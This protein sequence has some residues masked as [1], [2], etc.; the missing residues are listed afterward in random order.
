M[1]PSFTLKLYAFLCLALSISTTSFSQTC[2]G[3]NG[4]NC[5]AATDQ[6][7]TA[8]FGNTSGNFTY[9]PGAPTGGYTTTNGNVNGFINIFSYTLSVQSSNFLVGGQITNGLNRIVSGANAATIQIYLAGTNTIL[10]QTPVT[11]QANG[12]VSASFSGLAGTNVRVNFIFN[13]TTNGGVTFDNFGTDPAQVVLPVRFIGFEGKKTNTGLQLT[14]KVAGE[15]NVNRYE[16]ERNNGA[17]FSKIGTVPATGNSSYTFTDAA[18]HGGA[19]VYRIKNVDNDGQI[20][21]STLLSFRN[22]VGSAVFRAVPT[23]AHSRT[24]VQHAAATGVETLTLSTAD[25]R[26]VRTVRP[27]A[28]SLK[29]NVDLS[30]LQSGLYLLK[31]SN[32]KGSVETAKL[33]KQ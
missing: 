29:T 19:V 33:V 9:N 16:V 7:A 12:C 30:S 14:W 25:G 15:I 1:K 24:E 11:V 21:Y 23:V 5:V 26:V 27:A 13:K 2:T 28:G 8:S 31:W 18:S 4:T 10:C 22:G 32:G 3:T 6:F 17:G 20:K